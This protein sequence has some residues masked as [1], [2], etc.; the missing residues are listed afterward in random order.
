MFVR[1]TWW[2]STCD[3]GFRAGQWME[4]TNRFDIQKTSWD[5]Q[6]LAFQKKK[7]SKFLGV[8]KNLVGAQ[9]KKE[10][11]K[12]L[13]EWKNQFLTSPTLAG[14]IDKETRQVIL[15][16]FFFLMSLTPAETG[17][18]FWTILVRL[19]SRRWFFFAVSCHRAYNSFVVFLGVCM[20][21]VLVETRKKWM[22]IQRNENGRL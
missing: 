6:S 10:K 17:L 9:T 7:K 2:R 13:G 14:F 5:R 4:N 19:R 3:E 11:Q 22:T 1:Q 12:F 18:S 21:P 15:S 16:K 8:W 20:N